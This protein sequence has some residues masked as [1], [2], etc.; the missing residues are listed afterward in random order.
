MQLVTVIW[1][2]GISVFIDMVHD[3]AH[4]FETIILLSCMHHFTGLPFTKRRTPEKV[5]LVSP[6][7][8]R[9]KESLKALH[10]SPL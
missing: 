5:V 4:F 1:Y 6:F 2:S 3:F 10:S 8:R 9:K 7:F